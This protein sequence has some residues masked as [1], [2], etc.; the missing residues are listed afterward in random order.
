MGQKRVKSLVLELTT[1]KM[2]DTFRDH[3]TNVLNTNAVAH[4]YIE[5]MSIAKSQ[6]GNFSALMLDLDGF[7][8]INEDHDTP[9]GDRCLREVALLLAETIRGESD[10]LLRY[11]HGDEFLILL[12][13]TS[14]ESAEF[15]AKRITR[16]V[17]KTPFLVNDEQVRE[18]L[19]ASVA[20]TGINV[21][22]DDL[23]SVTARLE[24][25]LKKAKKI[26]NTY[27]KA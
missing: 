22:T 24:T 27:V 15:V 14:G 16:L 23:D 13:E 20:F 8:R 5:C 12:P 6:G 2:H 1:V 9:G 3:I 18:K 26:K 19:T 17:E 7:K 4:T 21:N 10:K 11:R 25:G